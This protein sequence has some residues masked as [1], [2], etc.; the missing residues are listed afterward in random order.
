MITDL[1]D[2]I[3]KRYAKIQEEDFE[4]SDMIYYYL[5]EQGTE[6][7]YDLDSSEFKRIMT[8]ACEKVL[9]GVY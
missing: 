7:Y 3:E 9:N 8:K 5:I 2:E 1:P 6:K 4:F